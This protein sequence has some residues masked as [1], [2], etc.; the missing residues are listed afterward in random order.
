M[1]KKVTAIAVREEHIVPPD[2]TLAKKEYELGQAISG[3]AESFVRTGETLNSISIG[4]DYEQAGYKS[5]KAYLKERQP[6]GIKPA[7]AYQIMKATEVRKR[8]PELNGSLPRADYV[9]TEKTIR[10]LTHSDFTTGDHRRLG[11]KILTRLKRGEKLTAKLVK[12]ICDD[13]RGVENTKRKKKIKEVLSTDTA[14]QV[15]NNIGVEVK[16]WQTSLEE[17][18]E[19]FWDDAEADDPGCVKR[20]M[21]NLSDLASSLGSPTSSWK[22]A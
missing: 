22:N 2:S 6:F 20:L 4:R 16:L 14:Y 1:A 3:M 17:F 5:F 10:P 18:P 13:D 21:G 11:T 15:L 7:Y 9:W 8:L 12:E 19:S